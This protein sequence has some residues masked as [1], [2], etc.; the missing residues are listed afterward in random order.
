M[1]RMLQL[2]QMS[3]FPYHLWSDFFVGSEEAK[4]TIQEV[5]FLE[6]AIP[7]RPNDKILDLCCGNGRHSIELM[8]RGFEVTGLDLSPE[9][10]QRATEG[11]KKR[12]LS[13]PLIEADMEDFQASADY[14]VVISMFQSF[15]YTH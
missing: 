10:L 14:D 11:A 9:M 6:K 13:L 2:L 8:A 3:L 1:T 4:H 7:L 12:G 15:G 5:D